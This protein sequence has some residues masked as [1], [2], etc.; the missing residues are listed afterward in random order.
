MGKAGTARPGEM[1]ARAGLR[2][3]SSLLVVY[4]PG[5]D[6]G[7][8]DPVA[9]EAIEVGCTLGARVAVLAD[10]ISQREFV[11][12]LGFGTRLTGV[13]SIEEIAAQAG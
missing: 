13:V 10:T 9:I 4:G 7:I 1:F 6:D 8:V 3:G 5:A 2:A 12:S 11:G